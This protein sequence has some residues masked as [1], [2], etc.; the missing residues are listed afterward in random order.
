MNE[1]IIA[2][3]DIPVSDKTRGLHLVCG[4]SY[5]PGGEAYDTWVR[6]KEIGYRYERRSS[7]SEELAKEHF[8]R[9]IQELGGSLADIVLTPA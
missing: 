5:F 9:R 8:F 4:Y 2:Q 7:H 3:C 6:D 1:V